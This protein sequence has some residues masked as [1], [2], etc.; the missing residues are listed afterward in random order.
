MYRDASRPITRR[1][2]DL[3]SRM[4]LEE[5]VAQLC[6]CW[7]FDLLGPSGYE[8]ERMKSKLSHGIG[9]I[10]RLA[11]MSPEPP[12]KTAEAVNTIQR[13]LVESTRLG[14]PAIFHEECLCGYQARQ[15]TV[16]PQAIGLA[17]TW[18]PDLV[19]KMAD[20]IRQEM[21]AAGARQGL[22]PVLDI[23]RDPRWGRT[24]ETFGEDPYLASV[25][26]KAYVQG[27]QGDRLSEGVIATAKHFIGYGGS[28]GGLNWAPA[29]IPPRELREVFARP[30]ETAIREAGLASVMNAYNELDGIPC[31]VSREMLTDFLRGQLGFQGLVV[32]DY[33]AIE[34]ASHYHRVSR[35]FL[36]AGVQAIRAGMDV[37]LPS[38]TAYAFLVAAVKEGLVDA[39]TIDTSVRRALEAKF[40]L[41]L[42]D[43]PYVDTDRI[44]EVFARPEAG[45]VSRRLALESMTLLKN[46]GGLL[47]LR[48]DLRSIA[49]IGPL[50]DSIR[51]LLGDYNYVSFTEG[52]VGT[53]QSMA[54]EAGIDPV[55]LGGFVGH[56]AT[57]FSDFL[58]PTDEEAIARENYDVPSILDGI[59]SLAGKNVTVAYARGCALLGGD[60]SGIPEAVEAAR[61]ADI[62]I[63]VLGNKSGLD[64]TCT[65]GETRDSATL[66][67]PGVQQELLEAVHA[68]GTPVVLVLVTGRP[69]AIA[70]AA[71]NVGAILLAWLPGQ[72][73][74][75]AVADVLFGQAAPGGRLPMSVPR[76]V[77]QVPVY[78]YHKPSGGR[79]QFSG[80]YVDL[81]ASPLF[82]FG[83][84]LTY[85]AFEYGHLRISPDEVDNGGTVQVSCNVKNVG[86]VAGDEVVQLYVHDR[87]AAVTRPVGELA[88]FC[89]VHLEPGETRTVSFSLKT[90]Q[91]AFHNAEMELVVE[92]GDID[93]MVGASS[94]DIRLMGE[95][96]ITGRVL[97]IDGARPLTSEA[98]HSP[99][100]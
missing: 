44:P 94:E 57:A 59:R 75:R 63:L 10:S 34:S 42:F 3:I 2:D 21:V 71:E 70:W 43:Q 39:P 15:G 5:K 12:T 79:S 81:P 11:G 31:A 54:K 52:V 48:R 32:S 29:H 28:E 19:R 38:A 66:A 45:Q 40:R 82:P 16:F 77:G 6:G 90:G 64:S 8:P 87:E 76:S 62:A 67:L 50:S 24:E 49:V 14:I 92:P 27:L 41:G 89:R 84:G 65:C 83:F 22:A 93:V 9:Q 26:G 60:R 51:C 30:F 98:R 73:G 86:P 58:E 17:A 20:A 13:Y 85:T 7:H 55:E 18:D 100:R 96:Q 46:Q 74:G 47:P 35:D 4:T 68:T 36:G 72:E 95:F 53:F 88:G 1:V 23:T 25:M 91:L 61:Q 97:R 69:L 56:H 99:A 78:H 80:H 33:M 37:E